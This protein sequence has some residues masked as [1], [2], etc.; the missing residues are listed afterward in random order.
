MDFWDFF[1]LLLIYVPLTLLWAFALVDIFRRNDLSSAAKT[2]WIVVVVFIPLF[3]SL[4]YM[5]FRP[6]T[7]ADD[8]MIKDETDSVPS[9]RYP[10]PGDNATQLKMLSDLHDAGKLTDTEFDNEKARILSG[11]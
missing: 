4:I 7:M 5:L 9:F 10:A 3:G 6:S 8:R 2:M 11:R 1:W